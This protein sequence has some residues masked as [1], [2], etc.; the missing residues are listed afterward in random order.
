MTRACCAVTAGQAGPLV[1]LSDWW[2]TRHF[3]QGPES[4]AVALKPREAA[5]TL[6]ARWASDPSGGRIGYR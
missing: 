1:T 5:S 4:F 2:A 6:R 3:G